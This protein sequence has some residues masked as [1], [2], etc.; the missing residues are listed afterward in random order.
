QGCVL[1]PTLF[2]LFINACIPYLM[3]CI[4]DA[5]KIEG[6]RIPCLLFADDTLLLSQTA[7]GPTNLL[8][9]CMCFCKDHSLIINT[10]KTIYM[11]FGDPKQKTRRKI[12]LEGEVL[13]RVN[14][15]DY[16]GIRLEDSHKWQA[17]LSKSVM[18]LKQ[19]LGCILRYA[20]KSPSFAITPAIEIY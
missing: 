12:S 19:K 10:T 4:S 17:H 14:D 18:S 11:V 6:V 1:A 3:D 9:K 5:P 16:L 20:A 15:F 8:E 7:S 13:E 2:L